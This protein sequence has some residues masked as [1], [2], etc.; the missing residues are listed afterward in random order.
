LFEIFLTD[1]AKT[2]LEKLSGDKG[3]NKRYNAVKKTINFLS[4]DPRYK[5]LKT[6][7]LE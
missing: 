7:E 4:S 3:L 5:T 2:Q 1:K 6:H